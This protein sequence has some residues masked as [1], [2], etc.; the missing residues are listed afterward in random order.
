MVSSVFAYAQNRQYSELWLNTG[1]KYK[2]DKKLDFGLDMNLR[3]GDYVVQTFF[4]EAYVK[5]EVFEWFKPSLEY[6]AVI[7]RKKEGHY[8]TG[9]RV[10]LNFNFGKDLGKRLE[11]SFRV[12]YQGSFSRVLNSS[13]SPDFDNAV[14]FKPSIKYDIKNSKFAPEAGAEFFYNPQNSPLGNRYTRI[15]YF[16]GVDINLKGPKELGIKYFYD[17]E[18]NL[19]G[20]ENRHVLSLSFTYELKRKSDKEILD[21]ELDELKNN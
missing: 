1:L 14:R 19:P 8:E 21:K 6:R 4:P 7:D 11:V 12:R 10:N 16:A 2:F 3:G 9:N 17:Q 18:I 5:Y 15:R 13:Y 20:P